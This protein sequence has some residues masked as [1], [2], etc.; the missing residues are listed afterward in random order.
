MTKEDLLVL[1]RSWDDDKLL[2]AFTKRDDYMTEAIESM[3]TVIDERKLSGGAQALLTKDAER[4]SE[5]RQE[6]KRQ[7]EQKMIGEDLS[8]RELVLKNRNLD[9]EYYFRDIASR[10]KKT[11]E[12]LVFVLTC[13]AY[14]TAIVF[15]FNPMPFDYAPLF[16]FLAGLAGTALFVKLFRKRGAWISLKT[17]RNKTLFTLWDQ[18]YSFAATVPFK[19]DYYWETSVIRHPKAKITHPT[20]TVSI[21]NE[22]HETIL[23]RGQL[24]ALQ[25]GP[26]DWPYLGELAFPGFPAGA[27]VYSERPFKGLNLVFFK[28]ILDGL[29]ELENEKT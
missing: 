26:P 8:A 22:Q 27:R 5:W 19:Y 4:R 18:S 13:T 21:T 16:P 17:Q 25:D 24:G 6:D 28:K 15:M 2:E 20:L 7:Y 3:L 14:I 12:L 1:Y 9:G 23:L 11:G 10:E 29:H